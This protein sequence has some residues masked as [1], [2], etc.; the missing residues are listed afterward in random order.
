MK[1]KLSLDW[2]LV[3]LPVAIVLEVAHG[4]YH[5]SWASPTAVFVCSA[6]A[7]IPAAGWM[8]RATEHLAERLG[9]GVGGLLN[10]TFGNAAEMIIAFMALLEASRR[11]ELRDSMHAIVKASLT[12]SIIGNILLVQGL[13]L[14]VGGLR[15][16]LQTFNITAARTGATLL[17]LSTTAIMLPAVFH[18]VVPDGG[19][20]RDLSFEISV[21]LLAVYALSLLFTL[22]THK[23]LYVGQEQIEG[24]TEPLATHEPT[25]AA[26]AARPSSGAG[27]AH[28]SGD[29]DARTANWSIGRSVTVLLI[30]TA[31]VA[32]VAEFMIGSVDEASKAI[33]LTEL[34]V[35]VIV[36]AIVGNAAEH[37]TAVLM[38]WRN[39]MD[40]SLS[41]AIGSSI[42]I[43][44]LVAPLL[45]LISAMMGAPM[46]LLF[47]MP[48]VVAIAIAV[49]VTNQIAGD[50]RSHWLEGAMLLTV[51]VFL[52]MLFFHLP[53]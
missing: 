35:G 39:R 34:F 4:W 30:A 18:S 20:L 43:A 6:I 31:V 29:H 3:F 38:A 2:L 53:G 12:G 19:Q 27:R 33:G 13:A 9:E 51:Y 26:G 46:D 15:H 36:V 28:Q 45:V 17:L 23:H 14:L 44:L 8:G 10:A 22:R 25:I 48:E 7:I 1:L 42:Q 41:I 11:P 32:L 21:I 47:T 50:G 24:R 52:G 37:S 49:L 40:L 5:A 16:R